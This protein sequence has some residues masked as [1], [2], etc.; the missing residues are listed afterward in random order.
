MHELSYATSMLNTILDT[1][2]NYNFKNVKRV[3]KINLEIGELTFINVEQLKFAFEVIS[4][5]TICEG[6]EI[7]VK[8]I[9]PY[10]IC[11]HCGY[12][13][14]LDVVDDFIVSCPKCCSLSLKIEG[15]REFNIKNITVE[16]EEE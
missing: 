5:S 13:G 4:K 9:K 2:K 15:G 11:N 1:V 3:S 10:I 12:R 14:E 6:A 8:F 16:F 7:E